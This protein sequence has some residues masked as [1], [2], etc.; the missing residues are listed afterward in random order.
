MYSKKW[1]SVIMA[2]RQV[3]SHIL[4]IVMT[5]IALKDFKS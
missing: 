4:T 3:F 5:P 2:I 1:I